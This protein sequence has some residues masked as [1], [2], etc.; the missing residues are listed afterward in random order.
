MD[1]QE[2]ELKTCSRCDKSLPLSAFWRRRQS[3]DGLQPACIECVRARRAEIRDPEKE[4]AFRKAYDSRDRDEFLARS[5]VYS[6]IQYRLRKGEIA[7]PACCPECGV[8]APVVA[9]IRDYK[10]WRTFQWMCRRCLADIIWEHV[11]S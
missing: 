2:E 9:R 3:S 4:R 10:N 1:Q 11:A 6:Q 5:K 8:K 7:R